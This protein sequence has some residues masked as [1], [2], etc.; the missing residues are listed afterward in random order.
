MKLIKY[1]FGVKNG[2][3]YKFLEV[4]EGC[5]GP[6]VGRQ[7]PCLIPFPTHHRRGSVLVM[8][9]HVHTALSVLTVLGQ[10]CSSPVWA[11]LNLGGHCIETKMGEP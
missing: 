11:L 9:T 6:S 10:W 3:Y 2:T 1:D 7:L 8:R 4:E 5:L